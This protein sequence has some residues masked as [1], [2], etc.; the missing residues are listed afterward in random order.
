MGRFSLAL[1]VTSAIIFAS[2]ATVRAASAYDDDFSAGDPQPN[3][4][5]FAD[6]ANALTLAEQNG[7][8]NLVSYGGGV[9]TND[10]LYLSN[11]KLSTAADFVIRIDYTL[12]GYAGAGANG[13][14]LGLDFGVGRD[15]PDGVDSAAIGVGYGNVGGF[16]ADAV[17]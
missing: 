2:F 9:P 15:L 1:S 11:F 5:P 4:T 12:N 13:D 7:R 17:E 16:V 10:A 14:R 8:L 3:W 6:R